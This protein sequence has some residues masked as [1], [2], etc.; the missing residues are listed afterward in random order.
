MVR[1]Q[2]LTAIF[3]TSMVSSHKVVITETGDRF[4][5]GLNFLA[6]AMAKCFM[7]LVSLA[8]KMSFYSFPRKKNK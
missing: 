3:F 1:G 4:I 6:S 7:G 2:S 5:F 8:R